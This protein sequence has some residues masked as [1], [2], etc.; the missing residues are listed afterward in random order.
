[1]WTIDVQTYVC[2]LVHV[3]QSVFP[4]FFEFPGKG[5]YES[6]AKSFGMGTWP[7]ADSEVV[8]LCPL[9]FLCLN[10][11]LTYKIYI[12]SLDKSLGFCTSGGSDR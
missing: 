7:W 2:L 11:V 9:Q 4:T 3:E 10:S 12:G 1:M 8:F 5:N 6:E